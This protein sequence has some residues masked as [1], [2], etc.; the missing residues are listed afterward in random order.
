VIVLL[1]RR[2][3]KKP[4]FGN[5]SHRLGLVEKSTQPCIWL[6][7]VSVGEV[8][9]LQQIIKDIKKQSPDK[10]I[11]VTV[12]TNT[13]YK[14]AQ[15]NLDSD[16]VSYLPYDFLF[17]M[18]IA[19]WRIQPTS[20][21][22]VEGDFWPNLIMLAKFKQIPMYAL[23]TRM[24]KKKEVFRKKLSFAL[25][26]L[27]SSFTHI[28]VQSKY[29]QHELSKLGIAFKKITVLGNLKAY[30]VMA[31]H[32]DC[33]SQLTSKYFDQ[34]KI[35]LLGSV[36]PGEL[37]GY[38]NMYQKLKKT[39]P[40]LKLL[41]APRHFHWKNEL[42][43]KVRHVTSRS[44]V[45]TEHVEPKH[46]N[47]RL[48]RSFE[49]NDII[50]VCTLGLLFHLYQYSSI[51]YLGG[52]FVPIGGH[53]LLEP[54]VWGNATIMGPH[55][56]NCAAIAT[57][58]EHKDAIVRVKSYSQAYDQTLRLLTQNV[59][60]RTMGCNARLWLEIESAQVAQKLTFLL[61]SLCR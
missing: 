28:Y 39:F 50:V 58:L 47:E 18:F 8:L 13:G 38:L 44:D 1:W 56:E 10:S 29:D 30:N 40:D 26:P 52:T 14:M 7:A 55:D 54:A 36:H 35:L 21:V 22:I 32:A 43:Q 31:K 6:H 37:D 23:N 20:L 41:I 53:N 57:A 60:R 49:T 33:M 25:R 19:F 42:V 11:Y 17:C 5:V 34:Y 2:V 15:K 48:S 4:I 24:N 59:K 16:F 3:K 46:L 9:S 51:F 27:F 12:G 61:R 45:W